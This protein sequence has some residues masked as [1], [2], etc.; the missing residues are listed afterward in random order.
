MSLEE[1]LVGSGEPSSDAE[2]AGRGSCSRSGWSKSGRMSALKSTVLHVQ[3]VD[4]C[5]SAKF[6]TIRAEPFR[7]FRYVNVGFQTHKLRLS[8]Q[9][10][11]IL[12][13]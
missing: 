10:T 6:E 1:L 8:T 2:N 3:R 11:R 7:W 13:P 5:G 4:T 12:Q 9:N